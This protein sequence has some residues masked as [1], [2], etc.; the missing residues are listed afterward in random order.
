[1]VWRICQITFRHH[2]TDIRILTCLFIFTAIFHNLNVGQ[3][4]LVYYIPQKDLVCHFMLRHKSM[5]QKKH[6]QYHEVHMYLIDC[7]AKLTCNVMSAR[8]TDYRLQ[9]N[10]LDTYQ[11]SWYTDNSLYWLRLQCLDLHMKV[12]R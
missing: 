10:K 4:D 6:Y 3:K 11:P 12:P 1:M 9:E 5:S 7:K 8:Q 2:N